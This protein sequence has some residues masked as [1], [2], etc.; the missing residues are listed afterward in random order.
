[1]NSEVIF[2]M[3]FGLCCLFMNEPV[4]FRTTTARALSTLGRDDQLHKLSGI[5][6]DNARNLLLAL[7]ACAPTRNR[8]LPDHVAALPAHDPSGCRVQSR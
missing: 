5:C 3:R 1:M 8:C 2:R 6:R 7:E 4:S